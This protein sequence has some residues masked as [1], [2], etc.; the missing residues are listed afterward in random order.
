[1]IIRFAWKNFIGAGLRTRLNV[2]IIAMV[3]FVIILLQ[4]L[5]NGF[6]RQVE[7]ARILE[8]TGRSQLWY[9]DFDP[10]DPL[11]FDENIGTL[12]ADGADFSGEPIF[13]SQAT[14]YPNLRIR[15]VIVKG[16]SPQQKVLAFPTIKLDVIS[17]NIAA[18]IG[19]RMAKTLQ[20]ER[21]DVFIM[22]WRTK[23]GAMDAREVEIVDVFKT[24]APGIDNGQI[25]I[26]IDQMRRLW[27]APEY[28]SLY[29][30]NEPYTAKPP[31]FWSLQ[32][33]ADL[34]SDTRKMMDAERG[35]ARVLYFILILVAMISLFDT[36]VLSIFRR[37]KEIGLLMAVGLTQSQ[38]LALF[39]CEGLIQGIIA[40]MIVLVLGMPYLKW[41]E[42]H[43]IHFM[44]MD[45]FG[46]AGSSTI[47]PYFSFE[48]L[49]ISSG[50][51]L[52]LFILI[53]YYPARKI[54]H[55]QPST[56]LRGVWL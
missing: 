9:K 20:L 51:F 10:L 31:L 4:G 52:L 11:S 30:F 2:V 49:A 19:E 43:G 34:L 25:W 24:D 23:D 33:E 35:S 13:Y 17:Q 29:V 36:Q 40:I 46:L 53:S 38:V 28:A 45:Q 14:I 54:A 55:L 48:Q 21:G 56:A 22:R 39:I 47:Y 5:Y 6:Q 18:I 32:T 8:E 1:M 41:L 3:F 12:E 7:R 44:D 37:R 26:S 42:D 27:S 16:I 15:P 50:F